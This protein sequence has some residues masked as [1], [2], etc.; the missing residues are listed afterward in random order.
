[1][2]QFSGEKRKKKREETMSHA[3]MFMRA[4]TTMLARPV[5]N[6]VLFSSFY[7]RIMFDSQKIRCNARALLEKKAK[8]STN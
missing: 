4:L 6:T 3:R 1:M 8:L 5:E 7:L 2:L